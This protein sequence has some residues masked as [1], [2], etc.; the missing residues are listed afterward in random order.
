MNTKQI[1][2]CALDMGKAA[3]PRGKAGVAR[4]LKIMKRNWDDATPARKKELDAERL[5][6]PYMDSRI[7]FDSGKKVTKAL[8][9]ID[10]GSA[11]MLLADTLGADLV[12]SHHPHGNGLAQLDEVMHLQADLLH[13]TADVPINVAEAIIRTRSQEIARKLSPLNHHQ[14]VDTARLLN[15]SLISMHTPADNIVWKHVH[16]LLAKT[17]PDTVGDVVDALK[18]IPEYQ[19]GLRRGEGPTI[20]AGERTNRAGK[21]VASEFTGGTEPGKELYLHLARAGVGTVVGM[22]VAEDARVQAQKHHI[23]IV[24]AGH[25]SSDSL[26]MNPILDA[27]ESKGIEIIPCSGLIRVKR[28]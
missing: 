18:K 2:T 23:N 24:I 10:I 28:T 16:D 3:D 17:K 26:G 6:N 4:W 1:F 7:H 13:A 11:E 8:V 14:S 5:T 25:M 21:V 9:G 19:E 22:H 15:I 12:I 27:I 20:F